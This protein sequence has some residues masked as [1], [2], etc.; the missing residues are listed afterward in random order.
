MPKKPKPDLR[1]RCWVEIVIPDL[2]WE[3]G[4]AAYQAVANWV[5]SLGHETVWPMPNLAEPNS[6]LMGTM[7]PE[8]LARAFRTKKPVWPLVRVPAEVRSPEWQ[9]QRGM[10]IGLAPGAL[11]DEQREKLEALMAELRSKAP[12]VE[13]RVDGRRTGD[14]ELTTGVC[15]DDLT[16]RKKP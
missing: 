10:L 11:V 4:K 8:S 1:D 5:L 7:S 2:P 15:E 13:V 12:E 9:S 14:V 16:R 6:D 3:E